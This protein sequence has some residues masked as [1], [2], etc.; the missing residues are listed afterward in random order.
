MTVVEIANL[1]EID[2]SNLYRKLKKGLS[3]KEAVASIKGNKP[4][5]FPYKG[6]MCT[7]NEMLLDDPTISPD[8]LYKEL[9][10]TSLYTEEE[11]RN[12]INRCRR[13]MYYY[14]NGVSLYQY[15]IENQC[16]YYVIRNLIISQGLNV[17]QAIDLYLEQGQGD[18]KN[19]S[20]LREIFC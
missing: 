19:G 13:T 12:I 6:N 1:E 16:N 15:C 20:F 11:V 18:P 5:L 4:I 10:D 9:K 17:Q 14:Y 8:K 2:S 7:R 3:I